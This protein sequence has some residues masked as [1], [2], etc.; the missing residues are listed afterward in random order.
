MS[1]SFP[2][3]AVS[4]KEKQ[5]SEYH[6]NWIRSITTNSFTS[7]WALS[8]NKMRM[9]YSFYLDG[10]GSDL[11]GYLTTAPD[12]T[13]MPGIWTSQNSVKTRMRAL[14]G[15]LE[16]RSYLIKARALNSEAL[17]RKREE[18]ERLRIKRKL[19]FLGQLVEDETGVP[20]ESPE[21]VP[22]S[23][24]EL[25]EYL[26][27]T[28]KD[29]HVLILE[30]ALKW[31]AFRNNDD[32]SRKRLFLHQMI[33]G[34]SPLRNEI[35]NSVPKARPIDPW[36]FGWDPNATDDM[37]SDST[38][39]WEADYVPL[40]TAAQRYGLDEEEL[41]RCYNSYDAF[42]ANN[43]SLTDG[44]GFGDSWGCMNN[45]IVRWFRVE[46]GTPRCLVLKAC[47]RD[48][49]T[50]AHKHE[51]KEEYGSEFFQDVSG[52]EPRD[53][54]KDKIV[55]N[56]IECWRQAT[57]VGGEFL[58][59][60]G[61]CPN[62]AR[63]L[64]KLQ[65]SHP[66]YTVW[67][68]EYF[69]GKWTSP[70]EQLVGLQLLK[71]IALYQLQIQMA[72]AS[73]KVIVIDEAMLPE[74]MSRESV[75][76]YMKADGIVWTNS[77]EYQLA[78]GNMNL[79]KDYD[80]GFSQTIAQGIQLVA[81][82]DQ[83][84]DSISGVSQERQGQIQGASVSTGTTV[85]SLVQSTTVTAP[86]FKGFER[87]WS[88]TLQQ[89]ARLVKLAWAG[90]EVFAPIIGD[91]GVDFLADNTDISLDEFDVIVQS[92]PPMAF[93]RQTLVQWLTAAVQSDPQFLTDAMEIMLEPDITVATRK[94]Q[95]KTRL[96]Q[97][98]QQL[99]AQQQAQAEQEAAQAQQ[100]H[101]QQLR[102]AELQSEQALQDK[103]D[104]TNLQKTLITGRTKLN[105]AKLDLLKS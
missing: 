105:N 84:L 33:S 6:L 72:R 98:I 5:K 41:K 79:F 10:T 87:F 11:T 2:N 104:K 45:Q 4:E 83:Q 16:E 22:Q 100:Q 31:L 48:Y 76:R 64:S 59:E 66:P 36:K 101:E 69:M 82:F 88:R 37:L 38:F 18:K 24:D 9:L 65:I 14:L 67:V 54:D 42:I 23:D 73:G 20:L 52:D 62:Q 27:L 53:R 85:A 71:D 57:L 80:L 96:R 7:N 93:D 95:R 60:W 3:I 47:W 61:E 21:Y 97:R 39:F 44:S 63:D 70:V 30:G 91:V 13:A 92:L 56:K 12:G 43:F 99:Q 58:R 1:F 55:Y 102:G 75:A 40:A 29:K 68:N 81:Y 15:E 51:V 49:K 94:Y 90:K 32:E 78:Q 26:D 19:Q 25:R 50:L 34:V 46:E 28:W 77:K 74:G 17:E 86:Y 89:Q 8:Y 35:V 103:K